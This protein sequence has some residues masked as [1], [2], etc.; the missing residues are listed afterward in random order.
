M[1]T[2]ILHGANIAYDGWLR[3]SGSLLVHAGI[4]DRHMWIWSGSSLPP[5]PGDSSDLRGWRVAGATELFTNWHDLA[6]LSAR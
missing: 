5:S 3:P 2:L 1:P 6:R 4:V